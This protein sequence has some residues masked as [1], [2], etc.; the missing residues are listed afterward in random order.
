MLKKHRCELQDEQ[1]FCMCDRHFVPLALSW[2]FIKIAL[3]ATSLEQEPHISVIT[4]FNPLGATD[5]NALCSS[6][7]QPA[8]GAI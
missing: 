3:Y 8:G 1:L 6:S 2:C 7:G 5:M 4:W